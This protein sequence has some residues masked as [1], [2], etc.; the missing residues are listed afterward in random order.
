M[1]CRRCGGTGVLLHYIFHHGGI[2]FRCGGSGA[3][4]KE[5][6]YPSLKEGACS[7]ERTGCGF[8]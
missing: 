6:N 5:V 8:L 7:R 1:R 3:E 2:C 4:P